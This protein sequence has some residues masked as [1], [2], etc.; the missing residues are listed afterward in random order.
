MISIIA[1]EPDVPYKDNLVSAGLARV[2]RPAGKLKYMPASLMK[3]VISHCLGFRLPY[4]SK[5]R[6]TPSVFEL[7]SD[8]DAYEFNRPQP[9]DPVSGDRTNRYK[10]NW[11]EWFS[12]EEPSTDDDPE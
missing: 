3:L 1:E 9:R 2:W 7:R 10:M 6:S 5:N 12:N 8:F 11:N 4:T